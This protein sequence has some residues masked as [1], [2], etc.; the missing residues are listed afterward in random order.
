MNFRFQPQKSRLLGPRIVI[1]TILILAMAWVM[2]RYDKNL[3]A[4]KS[5]QSITIHQEETLLPARDSALPRLVLLTDSANDLDDL[6]SQATKELKGKCLVSVVTAAGDADFAI[7][8][9]AFQVEEFPA[10][11]LFDA[12]DNELGRISPPLDLDHLKELF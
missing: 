11:I 5:R 2:M 7:L 3:Q 8:K 1:Y 9:K 10:A 6:N 4:E 12:D